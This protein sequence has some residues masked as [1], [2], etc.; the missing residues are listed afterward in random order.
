MTLPLPIIVGGYT[1]L[2]WTC[3][4]C[5]TTDSDGT[6]APG[7]WEGEVGAWRH[8]P[9]PWLCRPCSRRE[10]GAYLDARRERMALIELSR[11][12]G[13]PARRSDLARERAAGVQ[14]GLFDG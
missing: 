8:E 4:R 12:L 3:T 13:Y 10:W 2:P 7:S 1:I 9:G 11:R 14:L 6:C 5:L